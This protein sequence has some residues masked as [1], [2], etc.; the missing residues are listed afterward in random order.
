MNDD[1][2]LDDSSQDD[3]NQAH[4]DISYDDLLGKDILDI[5]GLVDISEDE[6][7]KIKDVM[8]KTIKNRIISRVVDSLSDEEVD[9]WE[10]LQTKEEKVEFLTNHKLNLEKI[11][12]EEALIYKYEIARLVK[13]MKNKQKE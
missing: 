6:Q 10:K 8:E 4:D 5:L 13:V 11:A 2:N 12:L 7:K 1:K 3:T 9:K